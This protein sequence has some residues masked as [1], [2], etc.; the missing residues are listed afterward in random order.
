MPSLVDLKPFDP[1]FIDLETRSCCDLTACGGHKY[2]TDPTT[3]LLTVSWSPRESEFHLWFPA[4]ELGRVDPSYVATHLD[5]YILHDGPDVPGELAA[6]CDRYWVAH[7]AWTFD[8]HVWAGAVAGRSLERVDWIDTY[9]LALAAGLPGGLEQI[10]QR[11]WGEGKYDPGSRELLKAS[12]CN[13]PALASA[14]NVLPGSQILV[15]RYNVQDVR[16]LRWLWDELCNTLRMPLSEWDVMQ[17]SRACNDRGV[18]V[19]RDLLL[20]LVEYTRECQNAALLRIRELTKEHK[21]PLATPEHLRSRNRVFQWLNEM[22]VKIGTSLRK[23][24]VQQFVNQSD[25]DGKDAAEDFESEPEADGSETNPNL[26]QVIEVLLLR[27]SA[28]RVTGGK[29]VAALSSI[30]DENIIR[31]LHAYWGA[32]TGRDAHRR[33]QVGNLPKPKDG[34]KPW[35]ILSLFDSHKSLPYDK[36]VATMPLGTPGFRFL[37]PDDA[38]S[39]VLRSIFVSGVTD[40][41]LAVADLSTIEARVIAWLAGEQWLCD[42]FANDTDVY[43]ELAKKLFGPIDS[44]PNPANLP[45]KKHKYRQDCK[46][47]ELGSLYGLGKTRMAVYGTVNGIDWGSLGVSPADAVHAFRQAHPAIAGPIAG[48]YKGEPYYRGGF[49]DQ[50]N[51]AS[52]A[53]VT[54][55]N[56]PVSVGRITFERV[57]AHL[58][59]TLPSGRNLCYRHASVVQ[60]PFFGR[61]VPAVRFMSARYGWVDMYGGKWAENVTQAV[62]RDFMMYAMV[63]MERAEIPVYIRVHDELA[64]GLRHESRFPDFMRI[65]TTPP[66]WADG[67]V[68]DAEGARM[69]RYA[70]SPPPGST[71]AVWRNGKFHKQECPG[72]GSNCVGRPTCP[73]C[74]WSDPYGVA[75]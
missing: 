64:A 21:T 63:G 13:D 14:A 7:N 42:A 10:A 12:R 72:C 47:I 52:I 60:R 35:K 16:L 19:D 75:A 32:H 54:T 15:G 40:A 50:L 17:A 65:M 18:K 30:D 9:P 67:F 51:A 6:C 36:V 46:I 43:L 41:A 2:A 39:A 73:K 53:A 66:P 5:G 23:E 4:L 3:N 33:V 20:A 24:I 29:M 26:P 34:V 61:M 57:G 27:M 56:V 28:L 68:L 55:P 44:W 1:V 49:W 25:T 74:G 22:G 38:A 37:Q 62:A 8:Q 59:V 48:D 70:K 45:P 58:Y 11:L 71:D 69:P 31:A